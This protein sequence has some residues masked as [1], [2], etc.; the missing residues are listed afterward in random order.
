M[1]DFVAASVDQLR[2]YRRG[3]TSRGM[4][5]RAYRRDCDHAAMLARKG[6]DRVAR[7]LLH[8][9]RER[10][11]MQ[12]ENRFPKERVRHHTNLIDAALARARRSMGL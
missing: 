5:L 8:N 3:R 7:K 10:T 1:S 6:N 9:G 4:L 12:L 2:D 11:Y